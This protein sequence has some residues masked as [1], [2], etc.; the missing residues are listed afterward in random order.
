ME[1]ELSKHLIHRLSNSLG[2]AMNALYLM[3]DSPPPLSS[4][5]NLAKSELML[6][7]SLLEEEVTQDS[8]EDLKKL[9]TSKDI[10]LQW[11]EVPTHTGV[12]AILLL[13]EYTDGGTLHVTS[14]A[15][16][17]NV[18]MK[19]KYSK[20][21]P[22]LFLEELKRQNLFANVESKDLSCSFTTS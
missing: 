22:D 21:L 8:M 7:R 15:Q 4:S 6:F 9:L 18:W 17:Q 2:I 12:F 16:G 3:D 19:L 14:N 1:K 10:E 20:Q 5:L 13:S 11:D